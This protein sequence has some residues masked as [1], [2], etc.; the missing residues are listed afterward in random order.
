[1]ITKTIKIT[2]QQEKFLLE[3]Y[4][5]VNQGVSECINKMQFPDDSQAESLRYIKLYSRNE[6]KGK[7]TK[8]EWY[9][10]FDS[11][12]GSIIDGMFRCN[13]GALVAHCED[14]EQFESTATRHNVDLPGLLKKC[15]TLTGAQVDALYTYVEEFWNN[16]DRNLEK[17]ATELCN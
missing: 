9:F 7:F 8:E 6:L 17:A 1:M 3:N 16:E 12:N 13:A 11:L 2:E 5:N 15:E 14:A 10:F 4:K